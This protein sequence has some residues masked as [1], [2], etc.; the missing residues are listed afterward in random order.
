M[1]R[2]E[3]ICGQLGS[4]YRIT[5]IDLEEVIY[6]D[7]GDYEFEVSG[8]WEG[9]KL[10]TLYVWATKTREIVGIY[11]KIPIDSLKDILGYFA[12]K[13]QNLLEKILVERED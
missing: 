2:I 12:V 8:I 13:Y 1:K 11:D 4:P 7:L 9:K 10:C 5:T 6:R 3:Q